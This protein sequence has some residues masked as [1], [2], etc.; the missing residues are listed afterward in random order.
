MIRIRGLLSKRRR[1]GRSW[2]RW[3]YFHPVLRGLR[4][5]VVCLGLVENIG[6]LFSINNFILWCPFGWCMADYQ[7]PILR[8]DGSVEDNLTSNAINNILPSRYTSEGEEATEVFERVAKNVAL[9]ELLHVDGNV[10]IIPA[11]IKDHPHRQQLIEDIFWEGADDSKSIEVP[12]TKE[13]IKHL[14]YD[15]VV[16]S[17]KK[18]ESSELVSVLE[19]K[20][21]EFQNEMEELGFV[22]NSPTLMNAGDELQQLSACFVISPDDNIYDIHE[23]MR[24]AAE[25]FQ[26]GG[27]MGYGFWTLR[28]KGEGVGSTG[29]IA[30]GPITFMRTYDQMCETIAQGGMRRGAQMGVMKIDHPDVIEF[31]HSKRK[32]VSLAETLRLND[33]DDFTHISFREALEEARELIDEDGRVPTHLRNAVEGHLSNFNISVGVT[34]DF[35][36]AV[37]N[38]EEFVMKHPSSNEPFRANEETVEMY[39][40]FGFGDHVEVG[41]VVS[42][43]AQLV[44]EHMIEG[45]Y[46]NGEP[47]VV[48]IDR[49]NEMHSFPVDTDK[50][51]QDQEYSMLATNPCV[52]GDTKVAT[53]DGRGA[54][55]IQKLVGEEDVPVYTRRDDDVEVGL[56]KNIRKT[57]ENAELVEIETDGEASLTLTPDHPVWTR[58]RGWVDAGELEKGDSLHILY[59]TDHN[60]G[61]RNVQW[62]G[63]QMWNLEHRM[64]A[65]NILKMDI[66]DMNVHHSNGDKQDNRPENLELMDPAE[67][68]SMH[69][70]DIEGENNPLQVLKER[71]EFEEYMERSSFYNVEG[72]DNPMSGPK[73]DVECRECGDTFK[74]ITHTHLEKSHGMTNDEYREKYPDAPMVK[75]KKASNHKV[76]SVESAGTADVFDL[77]VPGTRNFYASQEGG[78]YINIHNCGEQPLM[79]GEA[80]NLGHIN[81]STLVSETGLHNWKEFTDRYE[82]SDDE[83]EE[84]VSEFLTTALDNLEFE[85]RIDLGTHF[86][87]NVVTMSDFPVP[88]IDETV[89]HNRKIGLGIMGLAQLYV[90]LGVEY[91]SPVANE[92]AKQIMMRINHGSKLESHRLAQ[93]RGTFENWADS[94]YAAPINYPEWFKHHTGEDPDEWENGFPIRN[95]NTTTI[96][97]TG[98]TSMIGNT[99]G[100]CEPIYNVANYK[101]VSD[102]VQGDEMLIQFDSLFLK[103]LEENDIDVESIKDEAELLMSQNKFEGIES[104]SVPQELSELFVTTSDLTA[105]EHAKVQLACQ[106]G[107]D[108]AISKTVNAPNSATIDDTREAFELILEGGG[109]GVTYYRDGTRTKQVLTTRADN[110]DVDD[111]DSDEEKENGKTTREVALQYVDGLSDEEVIDQLDLNISET[112]VNA[113]EQVSIPE[114]E[115]TIRERPRVLDGSTYRVDTGYG[116]MY[117]IVNDANGKPFEV[118]G[119]IEKSGGFQESMLEGL[120]RMASASLRSGVPVQELIDQLEGIRS[121]RVAFEEGQQ[122]RSIPDGIAKAFKQHISQKREQFVEGKTDGGEIEKNS[123][124]GSENPLEKSNDGEPLSKNLA[125]Q[126]SYLSEPCPD[127]SEMTLV[128]SEGCVSCNTCG[129]S[130]C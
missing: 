67:H 110:Q 32:D 56:A 79:E 25:V 115:V 107:V 91:G 129:W 72:E 33:P 37:K 73:E 90:Q 100:G 95:H 5:G 22:P 78:E 51:L 125:K 11:D 57:R 53:A 58:N 23:T 80:C 64:V 108:S 118:F 8:N 114:P 103:V 109:K 66:T 106:K 92:I 42:L 2:N 76:V 39:E 30:S 130:K 43:P 38:D 121:P 35:M 111:D 98:T 117:V 75:N 120:C 87:E 88:E 123:I 54:V 16:E 46:E 71:G 41:E 31:I 119:T 47:G 40:M 19:S 83:L 45:A 89:E 6:C 102:D 69:S 7:L 86:L 14:D 65:E 82:F 127:C 68:G 128:R 122:I 17:F 84:A 36:E 50:P 44:W 116:K 85:R 21:W 104:L 81:L 4:V 101:N 93:E 10:N 9:A 113:S 24:E 62:T 59:E 61:Y 124:I 70:R 26:S 48:F 12:L 34:D 49:F 3:E 20:R 96:A 112:S 13:N 74:R 15:S 126:S 52:T 105:K 29:G 55:E 97:P 27:G 77:E 99:T 60:S 1:L 28:P 94:K 63:S 18:N